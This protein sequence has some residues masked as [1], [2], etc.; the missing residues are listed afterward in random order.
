MAVGDL[1]KTS[2]I[3]EFSNVLFSPLFGNHWLEQFC[4]GCA[5][6]LVPMAN[7]W[8]F[9]AISKSVGIGANGVVTSQLTFHFT[10]GRSL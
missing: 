7:N 1:A 2:Q 6:D 5:Y 9:G 8:C 4:D 10:G 3:S